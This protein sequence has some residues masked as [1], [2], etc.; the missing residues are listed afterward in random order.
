M[1]NIKTR[2]NRITKILSGGSESVVRHWRINGEAVRT[3]PVS[4][5]ISHV[6][7]ISHNTGAGSQYEVSLTLLMINCA[8]EFGL[9]LYFTKL[10]YWKLELIL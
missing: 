6:L 8:L 5:S 7:S 10:R 3:V 9:G 4:S 2:N 1:D